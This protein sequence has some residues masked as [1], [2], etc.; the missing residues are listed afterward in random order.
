MKSIDTKSLLIG[1]LLAST[2]FF[3]VAAT[4][5]DDMGKWDKAQQWEVTT[6]KRSTDGVVKSELGWEPFSGRGGEYNSWFLVRRRI[7]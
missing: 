5:K 7:N 4:S 1:A 2:V 3:G 6:V